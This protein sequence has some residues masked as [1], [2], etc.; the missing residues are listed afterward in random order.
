LPL[1]LILVLVLSHGF[2]YGQQLV[3]DDSESIEYRAFQLETWLGT[4][5][6][7]ILPAFSPIR[8]L[9]LAA[10]AIITEDET[11]AVTEAKY[12]FRTPANNRVGFGIVAGTLIAPF[13]EFYSFIPVTFPL[14]DERVVLHGNFGYLLERN[15]E[16]L[17]DHS[18]TQDD[19]LFTWGARADVAALGPVS[20]LG[21]LFG[22]N[23]DTPDFQVGFRLDLLP[24]LLEMDFTYGNSFSRQ[25]SGLGF[26]V[27]V[28]WT[29][30]PLR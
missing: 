23:N 11:L 4:E 26:I 28:A 25:S 6:S 13:V 14:L 10:G 9:Q 3:V 8:G 18:H 12:M 15:E 27:G 2:T 5:E 22:E 20:L 30:P 29:P 19:H 1:I 21:E 7:W 24:G 16:E 17:G